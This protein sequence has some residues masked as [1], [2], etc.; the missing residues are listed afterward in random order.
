MRLCLSVGLFML[1]LKGL[2]NILLNWLIILYLIMLRNKK[3]YLVLYLE[4]G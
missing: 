3:S 1:G 2:E 4:I